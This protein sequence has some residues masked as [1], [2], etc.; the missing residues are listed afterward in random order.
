MNEFQIKGI[1]L[2]CVHN[3]NYYY[4]AIS[5]MHLNV[6]HA[7]QKANYLMMICDWRYKFKDSAY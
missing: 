5:H 6:P 3:N 2:Q 4:N 1:Y 7:H